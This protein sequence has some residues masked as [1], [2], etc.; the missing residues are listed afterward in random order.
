V[1]RETLEQ[2]V[3]LFDQ[4]GAQAWADKASGELR[5][6][7]GR[8]SS[9]G[10]LSETERRIVELV[11][12]GRRNREVAEALFLSPETV[13][14]NLSRVYKKLDVTSRTQLAARL[15]QSPPS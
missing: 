10:V 11:I 2:A 3:E 1:S 12:A 6:I 8:T 7:G 5:R 15:S 13:A 9:P 4:L 14:W